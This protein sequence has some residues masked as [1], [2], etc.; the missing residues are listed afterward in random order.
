MLLS[1]GDHAGPLSFFDT[2]ES[3]VVLQWLE[4][5]WQVRFASEPEAP[6]DDG[7]DP[8]PVD[9]VEPVDPEEP[10]DP[11]DPGP[12]VEPTPDPPSI[13]V[14]AEDMELDGYVIDANN[15]EIIRLPNN[16][17]TGTARYVWQETG[18]FTISTAIVLE[19]DGEPVAGLRLNDALLATLR[20]GLAVD[21]NEIYET[22]PVTVDLVAGD[23]IEIRG[24]ANEGAYARVD[25]L[26]FRDVP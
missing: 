21:G 8:A 20:Y 22:D 14:E 24:I 19:D 6:V 16:I 4:M 26:L 23:I 2:A 1:Y 15:P 13:V 18:R 17:P 9:P 10:V 12:I 5:E 7:T 25:A 3:E 11:V